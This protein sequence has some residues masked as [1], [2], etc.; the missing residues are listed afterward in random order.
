VAETLYREGELSA[1][2]I[3]DKLRIFRG[4]GISFMDAGILNNFRL[5][6]GL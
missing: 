2:Q 6:F 1:R 3:A 4:T 5:L